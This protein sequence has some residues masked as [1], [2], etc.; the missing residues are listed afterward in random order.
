MCY[1]YEELSTFE[2]PIFWCA[3]TQKGILLGL[4]P[5]VVIPPNIKIE[6]HTRDIKKIGF[7]PFSWSVGI[8]EASK[9]KGFSGD[10]FH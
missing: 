10:F 9:I 6:H 7:L 3:L 1:F 5:E 8:Q 2:Y 4:N